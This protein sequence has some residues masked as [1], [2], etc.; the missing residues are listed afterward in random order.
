MIKMLGF[1]LGYT[2]FNRLLEPINRLYWRRT[3]KSVGVQTVISRSSEIIEPQEVSVGSNVYI[4]RRVSIYGKGG[5]DIGDDVLIANDCTFLTRNHDFRRSEKIYKQGFTYKKI[6][7][8]NDVWIGTKVVVLPG[9]T[10]GE[11]AV[12]AAGAVVTKDVEPYTIV[13]GVPAK[14]IGK[15]V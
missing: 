9:V 1:I 8:K 2:T 13:G 11:G 4:G 12:V 7:V 15:R 3:L 10:I 6:V 14:Y 5:V